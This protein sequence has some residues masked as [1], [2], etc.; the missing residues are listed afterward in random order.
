MRIEQVFKPDHDRRVGTWYQAAMNDPMVHP[1][2]SP[3]SWRGM[4]HATDNDWELARFMDDGDQGLLSVGIDR[5]RR[6]VTISLWVLG[7]N[8]AIAAALMLYAIR[9]IPKRYDAAYLRFLIAENN[10]AWRDRALKAAGRWMWG[11]EPFAAYD[12]TRGEWVSALHF[13]IPVAELC[14]VKSV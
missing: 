14:R 11:R 8:T 6:L 5:E 2:L 9:R 12:T 7:G 4:P 13:Q 10:T 1:Y 3:G